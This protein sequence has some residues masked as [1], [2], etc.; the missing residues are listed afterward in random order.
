MDCL[1]P[2]KVKL[3][4]IRVAFDKRPAPSVQRRSMLR[5]RSPAWCL[6]ASSAVLHNVYYV[7]MN[8]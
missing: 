7:I 4:S 2:N 1:N 8:P 3:E 6:C 5:T